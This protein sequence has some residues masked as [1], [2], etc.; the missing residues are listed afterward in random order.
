MEDIE[1]LLDRPRNYY[2]IDGIG[3]LSMGFFLLSISLLYWMMLHT[4]D[5]SVWHTIYIVPVFF[6]LTSL[7]IS[8]GCKAIKK[9][10]T[11]PRT[12]YVEYHAAYKTVKGWVSIA[13]S[14]VVAALIPA[15]L[16]LIIR[17]HFSIS[18][19]VPLYGL[20]LAAGYIWRVRRVHWKWIVF[21]AMIA[22]SFAIALLPAN[23]LDSL[24]GHSHMGS[25]LSSQALGAFWLTWVVFGALIMASGGATF[26]LYLH[27]T[28]APVAEE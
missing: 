12:G 23:L 27:H 25:V 17:H 6:G 8:Y 18:S 1:R 22:A 5:N 14:L 16:V 20:P 21:L 19:L 7:V 11:Y 9:Q 10:I 28:Q 2:N 24:A 26:F 4:P 15:G 13:I 3:E